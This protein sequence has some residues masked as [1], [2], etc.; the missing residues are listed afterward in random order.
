MKA[1]EV[2]ADLWLHTLFISIW[3]T[4][5]IP[6]NWRRGIVVPIWKWKCDSHECNGY[7]AVTLLSVPSKFLAQIL[8]DKIRKSC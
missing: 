7:K 3:N 8:L 6:I 4:G 2:V 5:I 1:E